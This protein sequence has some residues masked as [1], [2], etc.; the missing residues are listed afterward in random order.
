MALF[1][2]RLC[3]IFCHPTGPVAKVSA[4]V[5]ALSVPKTKRVIS[6]QPPNRNRTSVAYSIQKLTENLV[7]GSTRHRLA[8]LC[9]SQRISLDGRLVANHLLVILKFAPADHFE[10]EQL[11]KDLSA[12]RFV[13]ENSSATVA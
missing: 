10:L 1:S 9:H 11:G 4:A 8:G 3:L 7:V 13:A 12:C 2:G 5:N 6:Q